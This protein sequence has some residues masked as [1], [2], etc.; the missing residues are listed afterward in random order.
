MTCD[1]NVYHVL[2]HDTVKIEYII[3]LYNLQ[4]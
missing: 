3:D 2:I 4:F 1:N